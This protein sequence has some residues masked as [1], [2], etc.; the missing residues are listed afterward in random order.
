MYNNNVHT[1]AIQEKTNSEIGLCNNFFIFI[2]CLGFNEF[3]TTKVEYQKRRQGTDDA[4][5]K[6]IQQEMLGQINT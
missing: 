5:Y 6:H 1:L 4:A 3:I 2:L